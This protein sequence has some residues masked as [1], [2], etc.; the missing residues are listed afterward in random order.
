[1]GS[2]ISLVTYTYNDH[3]L[4]DELLHY[5]GIFAVPLQEV[6]VVDDGSARPYAP[7]GACGLPV[8]VIRHAANAGPAAAKRSGLDRA[9]GGV[10]FSLDAD[11]RPHAAWLKDSLPLLTDPAIGLVGGSP[12]PL[13]QA[14]SLSAAVYRTFPKEKTCRD[15]AFTPGGC[16]LFRRDVWQRIGGLDD[17]SREIF[18]DYHL[19]V[20]ILAHGYRLVRNNRYPVYEK[21]H[22]DRAGYCRRHAA[23]ET[24]PAAAVIGRHGLSGYLRDAAAALQPGIDYFRRTGDPVLV[25]VLLLKTALILSSAEMPEIPGASFLRA[26]LDKLGDR[27][28]ARDF[29]LRDMRRLNLDLPPLS[30][31][32]LPPF[33]P[34]VD[35]FLALLPLAAMGKALEE[36]W[37]AVYLAEDE[38]IPFDRHYT[39]GGG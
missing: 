14:S 30:A 24:A 23:Y 10:I 9:S 17:F 21:R 38:K 13:R 37:I 1:M 25:Y 12:L 34:A 33:A 22:L 16:L 11:I 29:F 20:K 2:G 39:Q 32:A 8:R 28:G 31:P 35:E 26:L 15:A 7:S 5:A 36:K 27:P 18:E 6:L 3:A 4:I 19:S